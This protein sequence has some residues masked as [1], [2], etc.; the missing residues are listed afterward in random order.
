MITVRKQNMSQLRTKVTTDN[1]K[2]VNII[3]IYKQLTGCTNIE[4][5]RY[6]LTNE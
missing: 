2:R 6:N 1:E 3:R 4:Y 5:T